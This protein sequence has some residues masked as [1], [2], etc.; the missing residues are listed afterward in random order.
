MPRLRQQVASHPA[1][2]GGR[3]RRSRRHRRACKSSARR[4]K[5]PARRLR[6]RPRWSRRRS[7][8]RRRRRRRRK[9]RLARSKPSSNWR[10]TSWRWREK[11]RSVKRR[12]PSA[13]KKLIAARNVGGQGSGRSG[14]SGIGIGIGI[15]PRQTVGG[16]R[17]PATAPLAASRA[18]TTARAQTTIRNTTGPPAGS[19]AALRSGTTWTRRGRR[20]LSE[21]MRPRGGVRTCPNRGRP[22][23]ASTTPAQRSAPPTA[24]GSSGGSPA[25]ASISS[26]GGLG[27]RLA[28][29]PRRAF[30]PGVSLVGADHALR[31]MQVWMQ[32][33]RLGCPPDVRP[34]LDDLI[35]KQVKS[36]IDSVGGVHARVD[37]ANQDTTFAERCVRR[38]EQERESLR[39]LET[40]GGLRSGGRS[41]QRTAPAT[42]PPPPSGAFSSLVD[43]TPS[44]LFQPPAFFASRVERHIRDLIR[45]N[46]AR[47]ETDVAPGTPNVALGEDGVKKNKTGAGANATNAKPSRSDARRDVVWIRVSL[48]VERV[49]PRAP[50][51]VLR[52]NG[53]EE[54][55]CRLHVLLWGSPFPDAGETFEDFERSDVIESRYKSDAAMAWLTENAYTRM[56]FTREDAD[57]FELEGIARRER[58]RRRGG[59]AAGRVHARSARNLLETTVAR[60]GGT[61]SGGSPTRSR[62]AGARNRF[63]DERSVRDTIVIVTTNETNARIETHRLTRPPREIRSLRIGTFGET[64]LRALGARLLL[65][66]GPRGF[67]P[68]V[69]KRAHPQRRRA[70]PHALFALSS[71]AA[72]FVPSARRRP[73]SRCS[74]RAPA[75]SLALHRRA[76]FSSGSA[77]RAPPRAPSRRLPW[78]FSGSRP[79]LRRGRA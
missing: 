39:A 22:A 33:C 64:L 58:R 16:S 12:G 2:K 78:L 54:W 27:E 65:A 10:R 37:W 4:R 13:K 14:S 75:R 15:P 36:L 34:L 6:A 8:P 17:I 57:A 79:A 76:R 69:S 56:G 42:P 29:R 40:R 61:C 49:A 44:V 67:V 11:S 21:R 30:P 46:E 72:N 24:W 74:P 1:W 70:R 3:K 26:A 51:V 55:A 47:K 43:V 28:E 53:H 9:P 19:P 62:R 41:A 7:K 23:A 50:A 60:A 5:P 66:I 71:I 32:R 77:T 59:V 73:R 35:K 48:R 20:S 63:R 38:A 25:G 52:S 45:E 31:A 68:R 18:P